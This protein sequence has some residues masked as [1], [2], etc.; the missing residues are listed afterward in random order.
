[1]ADLRKIA[2]KLGKNCSPLAM[3]R[4]QAEDYID[5]AQILMRYPTAA[6]ICLWAICSVAGILAVAAM[7]AFLV[8]ASIT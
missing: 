8:A 2:E 4:A 7:L 6:L 1:M 3:P 5:L